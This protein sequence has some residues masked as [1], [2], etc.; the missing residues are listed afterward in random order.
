MSTSSYESLLLGLSYLETFFDENV[1]DRTLIKETMSKEELISALT[2]ISMIMTGLLNNFN[3]NL[4]AGEKEI[5]GIV[6]KIVLKNM[7]D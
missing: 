6:R 1:E 7:D 3:P 2:S 5:L 4:G